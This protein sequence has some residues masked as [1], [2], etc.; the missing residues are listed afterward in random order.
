MALAV[1]TLAALLTVIDISVVNVAFPSIRRDLG[2]SASGLSWI[3]SGYSIAVGAFLLLAGRLADQKGRRRLF[4]IGVAVFMVGSLLSGLATGP[5]W[6]ISARVLQGIGGSILSPASLSMVLPEFPKERRSMVIGIWGASASLGA[7]IGPSIGAV[8]IDVLSWR[9]VFLINVPIGILILAITTRFVHESRDPDATGGFDLIGVPAGT[10][11]VALVLLAVVQGGQ[12]GYQSGPTLGTAAAGLLLVILLFVRSATHPSPLLDLSLFRIRSFWSAAGGQ[13]FFSTA[14]IATILFNTLL[15]QELWG[16]SVLAAGFGVVPGPALAAL[17][18][19]PVGSI[20]DRVGHRNLLVVG[21][22]SAACCPA[23]LLWRVT[24]DSPYLVT[25]LPAQMFLG[26]GVACSFATF[27]S[28]GLS[29]VTPA[30]FGT[31]SASLR[32]GSSLGFASGVSIAIAV[33]SSSAASGPLVAFDRAWTF[34]AVV[35]VACALF[36][37]VACPGRSPVRPPSPG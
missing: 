5:V 26:I 10:V 11:G 12:W 20:T 15:L 17:M 14:F 19:G 34:M 18:G 2:A 24:M 7:A 28:L 1:S 23:W 37:A 9:W 21:S 3:L 6:L 32:T 35:F 8:L 16:W 27:S 4:M 36:C 33:F 25:V 22:L 13:T 29:E 30:R 31:A